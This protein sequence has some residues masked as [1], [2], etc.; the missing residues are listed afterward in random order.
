MNKITSIILLCNILK[1]DA[2]GR[3]YEDAWY[4]E[5]YSTLEKSEST[6]YNEMFIIGSFLFF[7]LWVLCPFTERVLKILKELNDPYH[8][9]TD[10][11]YKNEELQTEINGLS[12][13]INELKQHFTDNII[14]NRQRFQDY[15]EINAMHQKELNI[16]L[17]RTSK[18]EEKFAVMIASISGIYAKL[19][20]LEKTVSNSEDDKKSEEEQEN[21]LEYDVAEEKHNLYRATLDN[22]EVV[23]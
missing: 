5:S 15:K 9:Q 14:L 22:F 6:F 23:S 4:D 7:I 20:H 19:E 2:I 8:F 3:K 1:I 16:F 13:E 17:K 11:S 18:L 10:E 21:V 12:N